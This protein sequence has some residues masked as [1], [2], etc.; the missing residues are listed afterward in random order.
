MKATYKRRMELEILPAVSSYFLEQL[1]LL[2]QTKEMVMIIDLD[3]HQG[4]GHKK[5]LPKLSIENMTRMLM[6]R[7]VHEIIKRHQAQ[8]SI[9]LKHP[10]IS[11]R[12][13]SLHLLYVMCHVT[14][15]KDIVAELLQILQCGKSWH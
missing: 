5:D 2:L 9:S 6:V 13:R 7:D 14:N 10:D 12:R 3:A 15:A 11:I 1:C 8:I 4:N